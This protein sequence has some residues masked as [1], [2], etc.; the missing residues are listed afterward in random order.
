MSVN[1]MRVAQVPLFTGT[2]NKWVKG[3]L[4][5]ALNDLEA[6]LLVHLF[7]NDIILNGEEEL[8]SFDLPTWT[9]Y[10]GDAVTWNGPS[11][12]PVAQVIMTSTEAYWTVGATADVTVF[13]AFMYVTDPG[14]VLLAMRFDEPV[15]ATPGVPISVIWEWTMR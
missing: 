4:F 7:T 3:R 1:V 6:D 2:I 13:G 12:V 15:L 9:A 10:A 14:A 8:T 5:G 11:E